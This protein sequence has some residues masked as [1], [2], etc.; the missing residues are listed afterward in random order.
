MAD[1]AESTGVSWLDDL[2]DEYPTNRTVT[3]QLRLF[4]VFK[5]EGDA[6]MVE[7][8]TQY[9]RHESFFP[10]V[11]SLRPYVD[12]A[13]ERARVKPKA[14]PAVML[15]YEQAQGWMP[16]DDEL[17]NAADWLAIIDK[18]TAGEWKEEE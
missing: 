15:A 7:A 1:E 17:H 5:Q 18:A 11:S 16:P 8:V 10:R 2:I 3:A 4:R 12:A 9:I 13:K 14:D 6:T